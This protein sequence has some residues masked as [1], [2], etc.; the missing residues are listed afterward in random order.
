[1]VGRSVFQSTVG[2]SPS[3]YEKKKHR[4]NEKSDD[5]RSC[6]L[7]PE[8]DR[9]PHLPLVRLDFFYVKFSALDGLQGLF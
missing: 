7:F 2:V 3:L 1:M 6:A 8:N 4:E 9:A 5:S